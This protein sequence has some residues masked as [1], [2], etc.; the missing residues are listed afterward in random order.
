MYSNNVSDALNEY[1]TTIIKP[2]VKQNEIEDIDI[3]PDV[4]EDQI[5][6]DDNLT[7]VLNLEDIESKFDDIM[8]KT[9]Q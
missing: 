7:P 6:A 9:F 1:F 3:Q 8:T 4:R 5:M 2:R